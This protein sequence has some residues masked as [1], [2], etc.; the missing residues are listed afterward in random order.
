MR[1][2]SNTGTETECSPT[3][4]ESM[5]VRASSGTTSQSI[6]QNNFGQTRRLNQNSRAVQWC[7]SSMGRAKHCRAFILRRRTDHRDLVDAFQSHNP[8]VVSSNL[9][10]ATNL[11]DSQGLAECFQQALL[12]FG[13]DLGKKSV[14]L[15]QSQ[16]I[17]SRTIH[18]VSRLRSVHHRKKYECNRPSHYFR[19]GQTLPPNLLWDAKRIHC[20]GRRV[21]E[22]VQS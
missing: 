4:W 21:T 8:K 7:A 16:A 12:L 5:I 13:K 2:S 6:S 18:Q 14:F 19:C 3:R 17:R 20:C 22:T 15:Y 9:T 10:P 11:T 1:G